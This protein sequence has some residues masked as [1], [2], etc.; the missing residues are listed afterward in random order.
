MIFPRPNLSCTS[1][2]K[3]HARKRTSRNNFKTSFNSNKIIARMALNQNVF[4]ST[5]PTFYDKDEAD[6]T[7]T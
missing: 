5:Q 7:S 1:E 4:Y 6:A 3:L 2:R